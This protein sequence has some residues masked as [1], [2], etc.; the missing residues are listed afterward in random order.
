MTALASNTVTFWTSPCSHPSRNGAIE[1]GDALGCA[2]FSSAPNA[3]FA[4]FDIAGAML[5][6]EKG[7]DG[8][9]WPL[10]PDID[11]PFEGLTPEHAVVAVCKSL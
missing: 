7:T 3:S 9:F 8:K 1:A 2:P 11:G 4:V 5:V 10:D 6:A